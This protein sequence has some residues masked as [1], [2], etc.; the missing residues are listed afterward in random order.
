MFTYEG[1]V[2]AAFLVWLYGV[3]NLIVTINSQLER[4]LRKIG[5]RTSWLSMTV[6]DMEAED[7]KR[8][9]ASKIGRFMLVIS[10]GFVSILLSWV[11][12]MYFIGSIIYR[13]SKDAGAP[14]AVR[15]IRWKMKNLDLSFDQIAN[16]LLKAEGHDPSRFE[17]LRNQMRT[18]LRERGVIQ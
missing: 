15:E 11:S 13:L 1:G 6:T 18:E 12:V 7:L 4:N 2:A 10:L 3:T 5:K 17:E 16:E 9:M 8:S 14:Q